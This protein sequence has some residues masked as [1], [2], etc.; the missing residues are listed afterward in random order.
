MVIWGI[1]EGSQHTMPTVISFHALHDANVSV[2]VDGNVLVVLELERLFEQRYFCSNPRK[3]IFIEQWKQAVDHVTSFTQ[4]HDFDVAVASWIMPT[5]VEILSSLVKAK[6]WVTVDH[7]L[8]H[9][10]LGFYDSPFKSALVFS[11]DGGGNDGTFNVYHADRN[12]GIKHLKWVGLNLGTPFRQL[13][14]AMP[15][16][17]GGKGTSEETKDLTTY[18]RFAPL[19]LSGKV[20]GYAAL[21]SIREEWVDG[22]D[23][24]YRQFVSPLQAMY[25][26]GER[27][28]LVMEP[29]SLKAKDA[30]DVAATSQ[31]VFE[32]L[33]CE[34]ID[35]FLSL[36]MKDDESFRNKIDGIVLTGGCALNVHANE[37]VFERF[38][39]PVHVPSA[40]NDCG[41][42]VGAA[43][44][45]DPP[46]HQP[47]QLQY[48]GMP[49]FDHRYLEGIAV[50][51]GARKIEISE[52]ARILVEEKV[53]VG[54]VRGRQEFGPRA[55]GHRSII[56]YPNTKE[57]KDLINKFK[58]REWFR[59]LCP[60]VTLECSK[61]IF[62]P[63]RNESEESDGNSKIPP[64]PYMSFA[65]KLTD[66]AKCLF[67]AISHF[68]GTSRLQTVTKDDEPW[69]HSLLQE[70]GKLNGGYEIL[71]NT[72]FNVKGKPILNR[73]STALEI[74][75]SS[76]SDIFK[77]VVIEDWLFTKKVEEVG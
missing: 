38:L 76:Q 23:I 40:P 17:T 58:S 49:L 64:S 62:K 66:K 9:A 10:A 6:R 19:A 7:H 12:K 24:Y 31:H 46:K 65:P 32:K 3:Q 39:L 55:L 47:K 21:G 70:V 34:K 2:V 33:L 35:Y 73:L 50:K 4:V 48:S 71:L 29:N 37:L 18:M 63:A 26:L 51:R 75:D 16:V 8:A 74:L 42:S 22:F 72:S 57:V 15:E 14:I 68:D 45:I 60:S 5:Q 67:P 44:S 36:K 28:K 52:I 56:C 41:I 25:T 30:R 27:T 69:Y 13:A 53:A 59:P 54:L 43:W 20:M 11:Y 77:Y 1:I 61:C